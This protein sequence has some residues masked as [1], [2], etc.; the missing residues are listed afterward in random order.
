MTGPRAWQRLRQSRWG[1]GC[2]GG[3]NVTV[4]VGAVGRDSTLQDSHTVW[5][6]FSIWLHQSTFSSRMVHTF[7]TLESMHGWFVN[8]NCFWRTCWAQEKWKWHQIPHLETAKSH[9]QV[10]QTRLK[11]GYLTFCPSVVERKQ[12]WRSEPGVSM[13]ITEQQSK[14][15]C[16]LGVLGIQKQ[17]KTFSVNNIMKEIRNKLFCLLAS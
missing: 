15:F 7:V 11:C 8:L 13:S 5:P 9:R 10:K 12:T 1:L 14:W 6:C 16:P 2:A 4:L 17:N 3:R